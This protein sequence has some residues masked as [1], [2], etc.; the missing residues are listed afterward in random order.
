MSLEEGRLT[1]MRT[2]EGPTKL[3]PPGDVWKNDAIESFFH[4]LGI[5]R[6]AAKVPARG[7]AKANVRDYIERVYNSRRRHSTIGY[8]SATSFPRRARS[9]RGGAY[10]P[11][12]AQ[13]PPVNRHST[14]HSMGQVGPTDIQR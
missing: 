6:V 8:A 11:G 2:I 9:A 7:R 4:A 5:E 3:E 1:D 13:R 10:Q 14:C 12:V